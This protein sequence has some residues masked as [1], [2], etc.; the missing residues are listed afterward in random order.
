MLV[1]ARDMGE[2][3]VDSFFQAGGDRPAGPQTLSGTG[4]RSLY[5]ED[6]G[7]VALDN[8]CIRAGAPGCGTCLGDAGSD[9]LRNGLDIRFFVSYA[10]T[11][12]APGGAPKF[13]IPART[14]P[15]V[16]NPAR[17]LSHSCQ[18]I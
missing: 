15:G 14:A 10:I 5:W 11:G 17:L 6:P 4:I 16:S 12:A 8:I 3:V 7:F 13:K 9:L 2:A 18:V 1:R